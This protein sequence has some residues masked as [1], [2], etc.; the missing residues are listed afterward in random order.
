MEN[1]DCLE[2]GMIATA[3]D[4]SLDLS[5][6]VSWC[7]RWTQFT[8]AADELLGLFDF[9]GHLVV[10]QLRF[11]HVSRFSLSWHNL[12]KVLIGAIRRS[13]QKDHDIGAVLR[14]A[15]RDNPSSLI[16]RHVSR[17]TFTLSEL[18]LRLDNRCWFLCDQTFTGA[19]NDNLHFLEIA[20]LQEAAV[21]IYFYISMVGEAK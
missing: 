5:V 18:I 15:V 1:I 13:L 17:W 2:N 6:G 10:D 8:Q 12:V 4:G 11:Q 3:D 9:K 21:A 16:V 14:C 19:N 20:E 7:L